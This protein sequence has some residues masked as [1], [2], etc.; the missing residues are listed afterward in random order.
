[1]RKRKKEVNP[2]LKLPKYTSI[3]HY[4]FSRRSLDDQVDEDILSKAANKSDLMC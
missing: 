3:N 2:V 1:M 4:L